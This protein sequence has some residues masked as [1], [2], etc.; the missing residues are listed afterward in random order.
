MRESGTVELLQKTHGEPFS[1]KG[2]VDS[3]ELLKYYYNNESN[4]IK[5]NTGPKVLEIER[6][7]KL[8]QPVIQILQEKLLPFKVRYAHFFDVTDPHIIHN[9]DE[10]EYPYSYK[11]FTIPLN[12]YGKSD[13]TKLVTF[14]QYYYDGPAK[15]F[16]GES[17]IEN[18]YYNKPITSYE[19]VQGCSDA[20][21]EQDIKDEYLGHLSDSWL[22]GLTVNKMLDWTIGDVLCFDSL[23]LHCSSN[24]KNKQIDR[25]I[26]LSIFTVLTNDAVESI[27]NY[28]KV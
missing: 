22:Q 21:I 6:D 19:N 27:I 25:K 20:G 17:A 26:G 18:V 14:D 23:S 28:D 11:A 15:F 3:G 5:K 1:V 8:L 10:F 13:D 12:I 2:I 4:V 24:F 16:N 9:D 7:H